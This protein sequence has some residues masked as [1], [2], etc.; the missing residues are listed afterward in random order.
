[1]GI[2]Y[3][4]VIDTLAASAKFGMWCTL[5]ILGQWREL[6]LESDLGFRK[7]LGYLD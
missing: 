4:I 6:G 5:R 2:L 1:M 3:V 7:I